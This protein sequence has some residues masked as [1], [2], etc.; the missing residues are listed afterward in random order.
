MRELQIRI[1]DG[2]G[3]LP[4]LD[5]NVDVEV[6]DAAGRRWG[7]TFYTLRNVA[8]LLERWRASGE[9]GRG[10][11]FWGGPDTVIVE[12]LSEASIR[13]AIEAIH[14]DGDLERVFQPLDDGPP[15]PN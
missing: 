2:A 1:H 7:A 14:A 13:A 8:T 15:A 12:Q 11:Y 3:E 9:H 4:S 5:T 6:L 10:A